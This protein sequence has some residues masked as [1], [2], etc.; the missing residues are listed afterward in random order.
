MHSFL[1]ASL[2]ALLSVAL[3]VHESED[4]SK[5][6][7]AAWQIDSFGAR[8]YAGSVTQLTSF[9]L[10]KPDSADSILCSNAT[11]AAMASTPYLRA[12]DGARC[13]ED[14]AISFS[15]AQLEGAAVTLSIVDPEGWTGTFTSDPAVVSYVATG[16]GPH[17]TETAYVGPPSFGMTMESAAP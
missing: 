10:T 15:F 4:A 11:G 2:F 9:S 16:P 5:R 14:V 7:T 8:V 17:D 13:S 1:P 3:P 12:L 6:E